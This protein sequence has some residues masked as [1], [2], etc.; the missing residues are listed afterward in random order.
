[1]SIN[2][3]SSKDSDES[4]NIHTKSDNI[5]TMMESE[6]DDIIDEPLESLS[7]KYQEGSEELMRGGVFIFDSADLL[8]YNLQKRSLSR[9]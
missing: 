9:K 7:E 4:P 2:F 3:I 8:Y 6:T 1:M 5:E